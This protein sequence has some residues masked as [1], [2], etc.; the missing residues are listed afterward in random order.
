VITS[1]CPAGTPWC[2]DHATDF[3]GMCLSETKRYPQDVALWLQKP[4]GQTAEI[5][6]HS[7]E[8]T[9]TFPI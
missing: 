8:I 3:G 1:F 4:P 7:P 6:Y 9:A 2:T 5:V